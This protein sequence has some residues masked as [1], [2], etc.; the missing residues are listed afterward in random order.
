[1][2]FFKSKEV[3][4]SFHD[5]SD[6]TLCNS[7]I[8]RLGFDVPIFFAQQKG[9]RIKSIRNLHIAWQIGAIDCE[10]DLNRLS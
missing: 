10:E 6:I 9:K 4:K 2:I 5:F 8:E 3:L 1:M 7:E